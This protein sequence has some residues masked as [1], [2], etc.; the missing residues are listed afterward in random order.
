M[1]LPKALYKDASYLEEFL[2]NYATL[3]PLD[4]QDDISIM[5]Y[6]ALNRLRP[7]GTTAPCD[8]NVHGHLTGIRQYTRENSERKRKELEEEGP[9]TMSQHTNDQ[10][11]LNQAYLKE[12]RKQE[13]TRW[14]AVNKGRQLEGLRK[15]MERRAR[16]ATIEYYITKLQHSIMV[17]P[18][19]KLEIEMIRQDVQD[20]IQRQYGGHKGINVFLFGSHV[21]GLSHKSSDVDLAVMDPSNS[22]G[23]PRALI[24]ILK[25]KGYE[26]KTVL[27]RIRVPIVTFYDPKTQLTCDICLNEPL[28]LENSR[29]LGTYRQIED[30]FLPVFVAFHHLAKNQEILGS[31]KYLLSSYALTLMLIAY[32]Q[33]C[34]ILPKLQDPN[35]RQYLTEKSAGG[36]DCTF[37]PNWELYRRK[38]GGDEESVALLLRRL[39]RYYGYMC[40]Y[41]TLDLNARK[42]ICQTRTIKHIQDPQEQQKLLAAPICIMDPFILDRNVAHLITKP[43]VQR[44]RTAFQKA[45]VSLESGKLQNVF[46]A[47]SAASDSVPRKT[48]VALDPIPRK[49][50]KK[51][52]HDPTAST[53]NRR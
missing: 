21:S 12:Q 4:C 13:S 2:T 16:H 5:I 11:E 52:G 35:R 6:E 43:N 17:S 39:C 51:R 1:I 42:G 29:L 40:D 9:L 7:R 22:I 49:V 10:W 41:A 44:I 33:T 38:S 14:E 19:M 45:Y 3:V 8:T 24:W 36:W 28:G 27:D 48:E 26:I 18:S 23:R 47:E 37:D 15:H 25:A 20:G 53:E 50:R 31:F 34:D 30:R 46:N 32:L